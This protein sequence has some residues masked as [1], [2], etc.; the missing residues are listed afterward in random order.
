L[1]K[2]KPLPARRKVAAVRESSDNGAPSAAIGEANAMKTPDQIVADVEAGMWA[3][4]WT[5]A[6][7][8]DADEGHTIERLYELLDKPWFCRRHNVLFNL[9]QAGSEP[10]IQIIK[11]EMLA[12]T[13]RAHGHALVFKPAGDGPEE[14]AGTID[15]AISITCDFLDHARIKPPAANGKA[16]R[17]SALV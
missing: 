16:R 10:V 8:A 4:G 1:H 17:A 11:G 6:E 13:W 9:S 7:P 12:A 3:L 14:R 15:C 2:F 5:G